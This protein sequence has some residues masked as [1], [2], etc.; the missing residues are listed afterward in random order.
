[1]RL[2]PFPLCFGLLIVL[3]AVFTLPGCGEKPAP[4]A[5]RSPRRPAGKWRA[6]RKPGNSPSPSRPT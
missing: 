4:Q 1:M 6:T 2:Y 5:G 3:L